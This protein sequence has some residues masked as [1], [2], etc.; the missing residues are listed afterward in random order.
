[1]NA[2]I[3]S[4]MIEQELEILHQRLHEASAEESANDGGEEYRAWLEAK[5][6]FFILKLAEYLGLHEMAEEAN[7]TW[8]REVFRGQRSPD[9]QKD[10]A[11]RQLFVTLLR[12]GEALQERAEYF[13]RHALPLDKG[14]PGC[15]GSLRGRPSA[16]IARLDAA[17]SIPVAGSARTAILSRRR[18]QT[19]GNPVPK[20]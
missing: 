9:A 6:R 14:A 20:R 1:M 17:G 13:T 11:Q 8:R 10:T 16:A 18:G 5:R 19:A 15:S 2:M 12:V 4:A 7:L 3:P